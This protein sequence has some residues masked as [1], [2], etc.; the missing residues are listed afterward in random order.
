[1]SRIGKFLTGALIC[2]AVISASP[3]FAQWGG[4]GGYGYGGYG[5]YGYGGCGWGGCG[6]NNTGA[7][8]G[9]AV[10]GMAVGAIAA[11]VANQNRNN[12]YYGQPQFVAPPPSKKAKRGKGGI[13][14]Q[15]EWDAAQGWVNV[16]VPCR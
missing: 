3:A 15:T 5:G 10:A 2:A 1:M 6:Y 4:Y 12:V 14:Y 8:V 16:S 11:G 13:C 7:V 9:A